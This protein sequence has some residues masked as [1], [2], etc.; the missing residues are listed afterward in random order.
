LCI[1]VRDAQL[2]PADEAT[3]KS[4]AAT[5]VAVTEQVLTLY[6]ELSRLEAG[7]VAIIRPG[8]EGVTASDWH[9][10]DVVE[11]RSGPEQRFFVPVT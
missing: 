8:A 1:P 11:F 6:P 4:A 2:A 3:R 9:K 7:S 10:E 5:L